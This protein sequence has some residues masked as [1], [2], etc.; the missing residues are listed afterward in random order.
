MTNIAKV[1]MASPR[2]HCRLADVG[3]EAVSS[4]QLSQYFA[5]FHA[6]PRAI[7]HELLARDLNAPCYSKE[8][9][10]PHYVL[11]PWCWLVVAR[12]S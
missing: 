8:A 9:L 12:R 5:A 4:R 6:P 11:S 2:T 3:L 7:S 1:G 10:S